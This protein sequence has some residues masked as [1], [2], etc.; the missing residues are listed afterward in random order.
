LAQD[1]RG[2]FRVGGASRCDLSPARV[3]WPIRT[4]QRDALYNRCHRDKAALA[5]RELID[6]HLLD[7]M[8]ARVS[9]D[10]GRLSE[11]GSTFNPV[12]S[13]VGR[14]RFGLTTGPGRHVH[15][16]ADASR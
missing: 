11:P 9:A 16:D 10:G 7:Q 13:E 3:L 2:R 1:E 14:G 15:P 12:L 8:M 6:D 4:G 5:V